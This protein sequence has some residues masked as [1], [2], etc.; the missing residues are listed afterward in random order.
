MILKTK[1][2]NTQ[3]SSLPNYFITF[4]YYLC[5]EDYLYP[6]HLCGRDAI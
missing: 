4:Y 5:S 6:V 3:N 1:V 2:I